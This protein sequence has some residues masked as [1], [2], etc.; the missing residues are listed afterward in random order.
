MYRLL[1]ADDHP[2]FRDALSGVVDSALPG[3]E[4]CEADCFSDL[5]VRLGENDEVDLV[6]L[7]LNLPDVAGLD[8]LA[9][10]RQHFPEVPVA[11]VSAESDRRIVLDALD[12]GAV[13]Y[14]PKS[15]PRSALMAALRQILDGQVYLPA[16]LLRRPA[17]PSLHQPAAETPSSEFEQRLEQLTAK[18]LNVLMLLIRGGSNKAIAR[19]LDIAETTV[20]THVSAILK[21]LGVTS[22]VQAIVASDEATLANVLANRQRRR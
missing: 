21:K 20:K 13:G 12:L 22:R 1:V 18:E 9:R 17:S 10:L 3:S 7:D 16:E 14:V 15:T 6:L 5:L 8:G 4:L 2:L 19:Q 11:V